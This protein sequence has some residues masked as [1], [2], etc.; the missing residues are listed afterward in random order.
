MEDLFEFIFVIFAIVVAITAKAGKAKK[1]QEARRN[2]QPVFRDVPRPAQAAPA[3]VQAPNW[4]MQD[5]EGM[6]DGETEADEAEGASAAA[7]IQPRVQ[8]TVHA[9]EHDHT[10]MFEGS[11]HAQETEGEDPC[12]DDMPMGAELPSKY[13]D[14]IINQS[15]AEEAQVENAA[16]PAMSMDWSDGEGLVKA[17]VMQEILKRPGDRRR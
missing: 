17:F 5:K 16:Q 1:Q 12:H 10:G 7:L 6:E 4:N 14:R 2:P 13:S 8:T 11:M 15:L 9:T 3:P